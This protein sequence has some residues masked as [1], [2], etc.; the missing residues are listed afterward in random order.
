MF[1]RKRIFRGVAY[2]LRF[3][4][5]KGV[6]HYQGV[7]NLIFSKS[8]ARKPTLSKSSSTNRKA[9]TPFT[10]AQAS[11]ARPA[12]AAHKNQVLSAAKN[13]HFLRIQTHH[14]TGPTSLSPIGR[15][16]SLRASLIC[17]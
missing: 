5:C 15:P 1:L 6:G 13:P 9:S 10:F 8:C 4:F 3:W 16:A 12:P 14:V 11:P 17:P 2:P 7:C